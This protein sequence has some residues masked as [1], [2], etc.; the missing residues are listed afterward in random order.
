MELRLE[1][2]VFD[3]ESVVNKRVVSSDSMEL[4][5]IIGLGKDSLTILNKEEDQY[6]IPKSRAI[7]FNEEDLLVDF[8]YN[9][10]LLIELASLSYVD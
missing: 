10:L 5:N 8:R 3:W 7:A 1:Q 2:L 6:I 9:D 4:G